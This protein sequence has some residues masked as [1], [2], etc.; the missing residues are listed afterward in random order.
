ML[1]L[2]LIVSMGFAATETPKMS[3]KVRVRAPGEMKF[4]DQLVEGQ[5]YR[6]DLSVV[7]G[8]AAEGR[9]GLLRLRKN[10]VDKLAL[11]TGAKQ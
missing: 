7:T 5:I 11:E 4:G 10:F 2:L 6:P 8:D 3:G 1:K 9:K